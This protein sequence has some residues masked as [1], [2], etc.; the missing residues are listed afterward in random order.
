MFF[1]ATVW[2]K[3]ERNKSRLYAE[4]ECSDPLQYRIQFVIKDAPDLDGV[5]ERFAK[6]LIHRGFMPTKFRVKSGDGRWE[7]WKAVP[8]Y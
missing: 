4:T 8:E 2:E 7:A 3:R 6:Q 1:Q 5:I